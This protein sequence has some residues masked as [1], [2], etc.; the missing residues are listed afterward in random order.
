MTQSDIPD[1]LNRSYASI[2]AGSNFLSFMADRVIA[3]DAD[4]EI[5]RS[6]SPH[7]VVTI[8]ADVLKS[9]A[10]EIRNHLDRIYEIIRY[11]HNRN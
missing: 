10:D 6:R 4:E 9:I 2:R 8:Q 11:S 7:P 1:D 3:K 5:D